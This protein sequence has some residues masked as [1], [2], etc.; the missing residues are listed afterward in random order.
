MSAT[1]G[2]TTEHASHEPVSAEAIHAPAP[3]KQTRTTHLD[4]AAAEPAVQRKAAATP[5]ATS[6]SGPAERAGDWAMSDGMISAM[7]LGAVQ[8]Y[9]GALGG[10]DVV[11]TAERGVASASSQLPHLDTI[12]Q[13]FGRHDVS[14]VRAQVGGDAAGASGA[15]GAQA[16]AV[17]D[18]VAFA[19]APDLHTAAHEAAHVVQQAGG[20]VQLKGGIGEAGEDRK[21]VV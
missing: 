16:Y 17:G 2:S 5:G 7:G 19:S 13:S 9:G 11:A 18:R 20:G 21:S 10:P 3:G 12:Q 4:V 15:L 14:G 6:A 1:L 8:A